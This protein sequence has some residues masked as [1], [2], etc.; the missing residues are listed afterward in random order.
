MDKRIRLNIIQK[1]TALII[2][3]SLLVVGVMLYY[4][5]NYHFSVWSIIG[6]SISLIIVIIALIIH[7]DNTSY[8]ISEK[9]GGE[10]F[11][12][13]M[14]GYSLIFSIPSIVICYFSS[15][16]IFYLFFSIIITYYIGLVVIVFY[17]TKAP[18]LIIV[19]LFTLV[20]S[21]IL[22]FEVNDLHT[23]KEYKV[24]KQIKFEEKR[25]TKEKLK[26]EQ[27][28]EEKAFA[29]AESETN[30]KREND[31][32]FSK[33]FNK[34]EEADKK[35][36]Q[37]KKASAQLNKK[38]EDVNI[39][40]NDKTFWDWIINKPINKNG[41]IV[42]KSTA[43]LRSGASDD[44]GIIT[45]L[46]RGTK[47]YVIEKKRFAGWCKVKYGEATG[48]VSNKLIG[49]SFTYNTPQQKMVVKKEK[50]KPSIEKSKSN[51]AKSD[52]DINIPK[53]YSKNPN[54]FALIIGNQEY[55]H[56]IE[57]NYALND[58]NAFKQYA[59]NTLG[60]PNNQVHFVEN[61]TVGDFMH[62]LDWINK[63]AKG[64]NGEAKIIFYY[65]GH[66]MPNQSTKEAY[67]LPVDGYASNTKTAIGLD[68]IYSQLTE[69]PT[70]SVIV[71]LD[72][73]F[74]GAS[75]EGSLSSGRGVKIVPKEQPVKGN[76]VV[77]SAVSG[78]ET[79]HPYDDKKHGLFTYF[80]LKKLQETKGEASLGELKHYISTNALKKSVLLHNEQ[81]PTVKASGDS[82]ENWKL[83]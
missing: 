37:D 9:F 83:K 6:M 52:V 40:I 17:E 16:E 61:A 68:E 62:E 11:F 18:Y 69:F 1:F 12:S 41:Y 66:G 3:H 70:K 23:S 19:S 13:E 64:Y 5:F 29:L 56:E 46:N 28:A 14:A 75:R 44:F 54:S 32:F 45:N 65:A 7:L 50:N 77:F 21:I 38:S 53:T 15:N 74:S 76:L 63:V 73:C 22:S 47:I 39:E 20:V 49:Y 30:T 82:W 58:A 55:E 2:I 51:A 35:Q 27:E 57:V 81:N 10:Y 42:A 36:H 24:I 26:K 25:I 31:G 67:L 60:I 34:D 72:A 80:L 79:A 78:D 71:F 4:F 33:I 59:I 8:G 48:Y 43:N